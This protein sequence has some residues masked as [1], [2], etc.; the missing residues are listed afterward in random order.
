MNNITRS[1][2]KFPGS[3]RFRAEIPVLSWGFRAIGTSAAT[4]AAHGTGPRTTIA[5]MSPRVILRPMTDAD[6][7]VLELT[8]TDPAEASRFGFYGFHGNQD[9][10]R[11]FAENG[12]LRED[13]GTLAVDVDGEAVGTVGWHRVA[14]APNSFTWNVG[15]GLLSAA[16]GKGFGTQAQQALVRY[17][18]GYTQA[19]RIEA[20]TE[21]DNYAEQRSLEKAGFT[22]EG[23]VRGAAFRAGR[24]RDMVLY[25]VVRTDI[26]DLD[27]DEDQ[28]ASAA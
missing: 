27:L 4:R 26:A 14:T 12:L 25:S 1:A 10:E 5:R 18:F 13:G 17:L 21:S 16:R 8:R 2:P 22:R 28:A 19:Y 6:M 20:G 3:G 24:W 9:V 23:V 11:A 15:I 7:P